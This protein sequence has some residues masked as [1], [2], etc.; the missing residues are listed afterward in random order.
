[1][2]MTTFPPSDPLTWKQADTDVHVATRDGEFAGFVEFDGSAH[3]VRDQLG[4]ELGSFETL[5]AAFRALEK[6]AEPAKRMPLFTLNMPR[7]LRR[8]PRRA[9]A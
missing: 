4:T 6:T 9:R 8:R 5:D 3:L 2:S 7:M 1:M